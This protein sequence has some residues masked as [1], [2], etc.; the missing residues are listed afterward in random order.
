MFREEKENDRE[1]GALFGFPG[2]GS[3]MHL[4]RKLILPGLYWYSCHLIDLY[5]YNTE[6]HTFINQRFAL[7]LVPRSEIFKKTTQKIET[8]LFFDIWVVTGSDHQR[9]CL[10]CRTLVTGPIGRKWCCFSTWGENTSQ[11]FSRRRT[12]F[13]VSP[14]GRWY[15]QKLY[16]VESLVELIHLQS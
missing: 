8:S 2:Q 6:G 4:D 5:I 11:I 16:T 9:P 13:P 10:C 7:P 12:N 14:G 3:K 15:R 1:S